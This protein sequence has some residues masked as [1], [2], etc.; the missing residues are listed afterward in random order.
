MIQLDII[1]FKSDSLIPLPK[2]LFAAFVLFTI[3]NYFVKK[4]QLKNRVDIPD[5]LLEMRHHNA[6]TNNGN[7][8][9]NCMAQQLP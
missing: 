6:P 5:C 7:V 9:R 1:H 4:L 3:Q 2:L 8:K